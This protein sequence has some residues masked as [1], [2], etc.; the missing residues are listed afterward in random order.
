MKKELQQLDPAE[1]AAVSGG[2]DYNTIVPW[3]EEMGRAPVDPDQPWGDW[4]VQAASGNYVC[5]DV[6]PTVDGAQQRCYLLDPSTS[7]M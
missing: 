3:S 7:P 2:T 6:D 1:L 4:Y 5:Q